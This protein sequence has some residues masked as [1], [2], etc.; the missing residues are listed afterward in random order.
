MK[1]PVLRI[2][3]GAPS[4]DDNQ[5]EPAAPSPAPQQQTRTRA[6]AP[7]GRGRLTL[8]PI[9]VLLLALAVVF[10]VLPRT[11]TNRALI[12]G[13]NTTLHATPYE[14]ELL[15]AVTFIKDGLPGVVSPAADGPQAAVRVLLPDTGEEISF[16]G[17]LSKSPITLRG[18]MTF[19]TRVKS[20]RAEVSVGAEKKTLRLS[21]RARSR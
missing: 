13:W 12:G 14:G 2:K 11:P 3:K 4:Y 1:G 6:R 7:G 19:T 17:V 15:V 20:V 10:R 9:L 5:Q 18:Q 8:L 21:A 16:G